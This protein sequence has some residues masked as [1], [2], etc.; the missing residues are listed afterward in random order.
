ML[1]IAPPSPQGTF[2]GSR[3][4][5][6]EPRKRIAAELSSPVELTQSP[7]SASADRNLK[8]LLQFVFSDL[9]LTDNLD[10]AGVR[11]GVLPHKDFIGDT[12][13]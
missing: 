6:G 7:L 2:E 12:A 11:G 10:L 1:V 5:A 4:V 3:K 13:S 9:R 8:S